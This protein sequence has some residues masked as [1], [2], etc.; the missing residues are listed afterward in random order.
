MDPWVI[1]YKLTCAAIALLGAMLFTRW[2]DRRA[3]VKFSDLKAEVT[4]AEWIDYCKARW[5]GVCLVL[6]ACFF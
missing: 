5:I 4:A 3:G 2:L 1:L 6:A